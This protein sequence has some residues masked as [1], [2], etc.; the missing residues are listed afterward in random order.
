MFRR[1][2]KK[3][4]F[5]GSVSA[6]Y[7]LALFFAF[8]AFDVSLFQQASPPVNAKAAAPVAASP[9]IKIISAKPARIVIS[10]VKINLPVSD[11]TYDPAKKS[12]TLSDNHAHYAVPS[13]MLNDYQGNTLIYGHKYDWVFGNLKALKPGAAMQIV[14]DNGKVFTYVYESTQP[15][16]PDDNSVFRLDGKPTVSVQTCS[17][18]WNEIRQMYNFRLDKVT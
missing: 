7:A 9:E 10:S 15:L 8:Q 6:L 4:R 18:R 5:Y 16:K 2:L 14:G 1:I 12:W 3:V 17:G 11:G 13:V